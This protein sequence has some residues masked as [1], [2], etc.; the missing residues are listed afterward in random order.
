M[1]GAAPSEPSVP[2]SPVPAAS[3]PPAAVV[4]GAGPAGILSSVFLAKRG[5]EVHVYERRPSPL[6]A[7]ASDRHRAFVMVL[8]RR[9]RRALEAAGFDVPAL[10][11]H[12]GLQWA[13]SVDVGSASRLDALHTPLGAQPLLVGSRHA[14]VCAMLEQVAQ[15]DLPALICYN[16]FIHEHTAL[17]CPASLGRAGSS[18]CFPCCPCFPC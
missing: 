6:L 9:G 8:H 5:F 7:D 11:A 4:C 12:S 18:N 14:F 3:R 13:N 17:S 2:P 10:A 1:S 16:G 15:S